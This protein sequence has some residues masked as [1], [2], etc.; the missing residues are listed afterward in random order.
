MEKPM[1]PSA[2]PALC[3]Q[4]I[5]SVFKITKPTNAPTKTANANRS[6]QIGTAQPRPYVPMQLHYMDT[7]N[8]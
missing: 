3:I 2:S 8:I 5:L 4:S 6:I 1:M 7:T